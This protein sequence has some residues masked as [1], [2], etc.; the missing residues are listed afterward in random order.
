MDMIFSFHLVVEDLSGSLAIFDGPCSF[1]TIVIN[2][3]E[4]RFTN[5]QIQPMTKRD[6]G[7][8]S[9]C[10]LLEQ[11]SVLTLCKLREPINQNKETT[12]KDPSVFK[13]IQVFFVAQI[14]LHQV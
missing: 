8:F 2:R 3:M 11:K 5:L 7:R 13:S 12:L 14:S 4:T 1:V 9:R 10:G 6:R